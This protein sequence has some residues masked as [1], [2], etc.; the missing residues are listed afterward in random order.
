MPR[1]ATFA[2]GIVA[3][4]FSAGSVGSQDPFRARSEAESA[5]TALPVYAPDNV[6]ASAGKLQSGDWKADHAPTRLAPPA[7]QPARTS[8]G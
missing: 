3:I 4:L 8:V 1:R 5:A 7:V 2:L 6:P